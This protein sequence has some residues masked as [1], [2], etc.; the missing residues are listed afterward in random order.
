MPRKKKT[1]VITGAKM[2]KS[3][4]LV[5]WFGK[6]GYDIVLVE[7]E[8]F[9]CSG[10]RFSKYVKKFCTVPDALITPNQYV[11]E[12]VKVCKN[13]N[14]VMF[15][16]VCAP[17]TEMLDAIV[18]QQVESFGVWVLH[19][20]L[21][22][23]EKVNNKHQF[24][25]FMKGIGLTVPESFV[26]ES[27]EN[28][29]DVNRRLK[30]RINVSGENE[31]YKNIF[32]L[33]NIEYDPVHRLDLFT[34]PTDDRDIQAYLE[35][36]AYDGNAITVKKPWVAQRFIDGV[37]STSLLVQVDGEVCLYTCSKATSSCFTW[38][39]EKNEQIRVW[40]YNFAKLLK[41]NGIFTIDFI[42]DKHDGTA[43]AI[44]CNPRL[45][46]M[47]SLF[48]ANNNMAD[49]IMGQH[50]LKHVVPLSDKP[51]YTTFNE[52]FA[53]IDPAYYGESN[54]N[55][56]FTCRFKNFLKILKQGCDPIFDQEDLLPFF[57]MNFFQIPMLLIDTFKAN[58]PW[59]KIDFQIGKIVELGGY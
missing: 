18:G 8:K 20:P 17:A 49:V 6:A 24:C 37:M 22:V 27:S 42:V 39:H 52:L 23:F 12:L 47:V 21:D 16:P 51:T 43:Y 48:H 53:L 46:S 13:N 7:T 32:I 33:K 25:D 55:V 28:V 15:I 57:M 44:E 30:Q 4:L 1:I 31:R 3:T 56:N 19:V 36:I 59:K 34:L 9:W 41:I 11:K 10:S 58:R 40:M 14:A 50:S 38:K 5:K 26:L 45:C 29:F 2:Y 54:A 35:K